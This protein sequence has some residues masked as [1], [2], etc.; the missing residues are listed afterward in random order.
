MGRNLCSSRGTCHLSHHTTERGT[1]PRQGLLG[2]YKGLYAASALVKGVLRKSTY[3]VAIAMMRGMH[4]HKAAFI[5]TCRARG[6]STNGSAQEETR[7]VVTVNSLTGLYTAL[8]QLL[9]DA[10][11]TPTHALYLP[12]C[13]PLNSNGVPNAPPLD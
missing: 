12:I 9:L 5:K 10:A 8:S 7:C 4:E 6:P 2:L 11:S 13:Y 1:A 3:Q